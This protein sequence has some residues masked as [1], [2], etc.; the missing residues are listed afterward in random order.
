[1][2]EIVPSRGKYVFRDCYGV[3][4]IQ[5]PVFCYF[6]Q[7][8]GETL[9]LECRF[10]YKDG[11]AYLWKNVKEYGHI[12]W[13]WLEKHGRGDLPH[14]YETMDE[15]VKSGVLEKSGLDD[16]LLKMIMAMETVPHMWKKLGLGVET[17]VEPGGAVK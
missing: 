5:G 16:Y 9:V 1:M 10:D 14:A 2:F 17:I 13:A 4:R 3:T 6:P 8:D 12:Q 11:S 7:S 15:I